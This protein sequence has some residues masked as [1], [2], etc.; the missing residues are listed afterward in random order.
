MNP[1]FAGPRH[2]ARTPLPSAEFDA[3]CEL[4]VNCQ[5]LV[6]SQRDENALMA[7][8]K[9][10]DEE[11]TLQSPHYSLR[12]DAM[13]RRISRIFGNE[14]LREFVLELGFMFFTRW[15][16]VDGEWRLAANFVSGLTMDGHDAQLSA[17]PDDVLASMSRASLPALIDAPTWW[18]R[19]LGQ[20]PKDLQWFLAT[21]K[22]L[23]VEYMLYVTNDNLPEQPAQA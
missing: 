11:V 23:L 21:N 3:A 8:K 7:I 13:Q 2:Q 19:L 17:I 10:M 4:F 6:L 12:A 20:E 5:S 22:F 18:Q 15:G 14:D 9:W 1:R 16:V